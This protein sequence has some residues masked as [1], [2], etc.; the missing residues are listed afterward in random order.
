M[1][2]QSTI[3]KYYY[4]TEQEF[5]VGF[6]NLKIALGKHSTSQNKQHH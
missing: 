6:Q 5:I 4:C 3:I 2:E 1:F